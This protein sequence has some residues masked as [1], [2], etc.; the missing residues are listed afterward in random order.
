MRK[1]LSIVL[2]TLFSISTVYTALPPTP[3]S[4]ACQDHVLTFPTWYRGVT[5]GGCR[6][7]IDNLNDFWKIG[8][9][10]VEILIQFAGYVAAGY[11][12]WGGFKY[13]KSQGNGAAVGEA[14]MVIINAIVGLGLAIMAASL[15]EYVARR[16]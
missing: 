7:M 8:L 15:V 13:I 5:E 6:V 16:F 14:K 4:A 11:I 3:V 12:M 10:L 2:L 9:N 1:K